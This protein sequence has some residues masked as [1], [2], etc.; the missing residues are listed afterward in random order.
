MPALPPS[1]QSF[2]QEKI[3]ARGAS[4]DSE[5]NGVELFGTIGAS[6]HLRADGT[7]WINEWEADS[8][9]PDAYRWREASVQEAAG[10]LKHA[11]V[12]LPELLSLVPKRE[13]SPACPSCGGSGDLTRGDHVVKGVWCDRCCGL[14]FLLAGAA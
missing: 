12:M 3:S 2:V 14:G 7:V 9:D 8:S 13:S 6:F 5:L 4:K 1:V 11:A 10:A